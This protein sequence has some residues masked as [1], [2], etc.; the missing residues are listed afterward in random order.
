MLRQRANTREPSKR[1]CRVASDE[2]AICILNGHH[3]AS[4]NY[5]RDLCGPGLLTSSLCTGCCSCCKQAGTEG[6]QGLSYHW[7]DHGV[8]TSPPFVLASMLLLILSPTSLTGDTDG[9][10]APFLLSPNKGKDGVRVAKLPG[11]KTSGMAQQAKALAIKPD[12][13]RS[14]L[15]THRVGGEN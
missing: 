9:W 15:R 8:L 12:N 7:P 14:I 3:I 6:S 5:T 2:V 4:G 13:P 1:L 11:A 10:I